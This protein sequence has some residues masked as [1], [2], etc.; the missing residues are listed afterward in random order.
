MSFEVEM[1]IRSG[2]P[3]INTKTILDGIRTL[4]YNGPDDY[5]SLMRD[6]DVYYP[7]KSS[8]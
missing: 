7:K 8:K 6:Y 2:N 1:F 3:N 5:H 4:G